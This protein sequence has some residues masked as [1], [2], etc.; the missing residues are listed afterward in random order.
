M[1]RQFTLVSLDGHV[2]EPPDLWQKRAPAKLK[3]GAPQITTDPEGRAFWVVE[4][5]KR[6]YGVGGLGC[7]GGRRF[8]DITPEPYVGGYDALPRSFYDGKARVEALDIA[9]VDVDVT[10]PGSLT[11]QGGEG[12]LDVKDPELRL[13]CSQAYNDFIIDEF[14]AGNLDRFIPYCALPLW[15]VELMVKEL[16]RCLKKG[17]KAPLFVSA[18]EGIGLKP[19]SHTYWDPFFAAC[20]AAEVPIILHSGTG[21]PPG[22]FPNFREIL[23]EGASLT[24]LAFIASAFMGNAYPAAH[25]AYSDLLERF[26]GLKFVFLESAIGWVPHFIERADDAYHRQRFWAKAPSKRPP[27]E[28]L[29]RGVYFTFWDDPVGIELRHHI[30]VENIMFVQDFPH[31]ITPWPNTRVIAEKQLAQIPPDE[32]YMIMAGNAVKLFK[33]A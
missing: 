27:S 32:R 14:C 8:E 9:G 13:F 30:G 7:A 28:V 24:P 16:D 10:V 21:L 22:P 2:L 25:I 29:R 19:L 4:G 12:F 26:P 23:R 17:F 1:G 3:E 20:Q 6:P 18:P 31:S 33:L 5:E 11:G 15:D